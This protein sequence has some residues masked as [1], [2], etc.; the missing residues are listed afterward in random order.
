MK[1]FALVTLS[2]LIATASVARA[3]TFSVNSMPLG[4]IPAD[5][6]MNATGSIGTPLKKRTVERDGVAFTGGMFSPAL[7]PCQ[8]VHLVPADSRYRTKC[9]VNRFSSTSQRL[10]MVSTMIR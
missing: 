3:D 8:P 5:T 6:D 7:L 10:R 2:A 4:S 9:R 1:K